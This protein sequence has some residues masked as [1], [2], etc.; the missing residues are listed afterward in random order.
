MTRDLQSFN[1]DLETNEGILPKSQAS[2]SDGAYSLVGEEPRK[3]IFENYSIIDA[4]RAP[5]NFGEKIEKQ[6]I[7]MNRCL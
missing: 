3:G 1:Y 2:I 7:K 5:F 6:L 4:K